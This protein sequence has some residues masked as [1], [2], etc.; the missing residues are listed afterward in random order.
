MIWQGLMSAAE[1]APGSINEARFEAKGET[2][3]VHVHRQRHFTEEE[4]TAAITGA[5]LRSLGV[6]GELDG[7]LH[8][9][10]DEEAHTKAVYLMTAG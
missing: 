2:G 5:G 4:V 9:G 1:V 10:L 8:H 6:A 3:S 7:D